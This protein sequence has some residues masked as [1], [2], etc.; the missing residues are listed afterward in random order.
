MLCPQFRCGPTGVTQVT[1][2]PV[3]II[4]HR[5]IVNARHAAII[6]PDSYVHLDVRI[7]YWTVS[8]GN[9]QHRTDRKFNSTTDL[10]QINKIH[11]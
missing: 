3:S 6:H 8:M 7:Y 9:L 2:T 4:Q 5:Q 1:L 10:S 11:I